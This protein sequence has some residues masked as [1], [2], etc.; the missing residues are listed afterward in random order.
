MPF[1]DFS[2]R[3]EAPKSHV[4]VIPSLASD[5]HDPHPKAPSTWSSAITRAGPK[6]RG[7]VCL[8]FPPTIL[9]FSFLQ[10]F[11]LFLLLSFCDRFLLAFLCLTRARFPRLHSFLFPPLLCSFVAP[12]PS[13]GRDDNTIKKNEIRRRERNGLLTTS[14][15]GNPG[16][17]IHDTRQVPR[18][19][20]AASHRTAPQQC[21][22][23][24]TTWERS[25]L[26]VLLLLGSYSFSL[27]HSHS[28][29][30][31]DWSGRAT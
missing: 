16:P 12:K 27:S 17:R 9:F 20:Q 3:R 4:S 29:A 2:C 15:L 22:V 7:A 10:L 14:S 19:G 11:L 13:L 30:V 25:L 6:G 31:S 23:L 21:C 1:C 18:L 8:C 26:I 28:L 5:S 24:P